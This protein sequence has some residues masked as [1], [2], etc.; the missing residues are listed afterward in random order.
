MATVC[1]EMG[2]ERS[3]DR[4]D[5]PLVVEVRMSALPMFTMVDGDGLPRTRLGHFW[6]AE[7][8]NLRLLWKLVPD[9]VSP[10]SR[11][12]LNPA[13]SATFCTAADV[14]TW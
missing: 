11:T 10:S 14:A 7:V 5:G 13:A 3:I 12:T 8:G 2:R 6:L 4:Y 1:S 9:P